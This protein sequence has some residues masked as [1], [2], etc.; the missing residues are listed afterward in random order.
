MVQSRGGLDNLNQDLLVKSS[1]RQYVVEAPAY[2]MNTG[3][4]LTMSKVRNLVEPATWRSY[5]RR[6]QGY[7][8]HVL[9]QATLYGRDPK[10]R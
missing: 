9:S 1:A 3:E 6:A 4:L 5:V 7:P 8:S 10:D 2:L